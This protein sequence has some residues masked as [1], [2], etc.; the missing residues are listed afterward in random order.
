MNIHVVQQDETINSIAENYQVS[1]SR[2]IRENELDDPDYLVP[3]QTIV[4]TYPNRVYTVKEGDSL[5]IIA[6]KTGVTVLQLLRNNAFLAEREYIYPGESLVVSYEYKGVL[7]TFGYTLPFVNSTILRKSLPYLTYLFIYNHRLAISGDVVTFY[8]DSDIIKTSREYGTAP[9]ML[10]TTLTEQGAENVQAA[11]EILLNENLQDQLIDNILR[12]LDSKGYYGLCM[13]FLYLTE[14]SQSLYDNFTK[15][16]S[17]RLSS[18]GYLVFVTVDPN[19]S[20][21]SNNLQFPRVDYSVIGS[22]VNGISILSYVWGTN[23]KPPSPVS[24]IS[25]LSEYLNYVS[26]MVPSERITAGLQILSFNTI[27]CFSIIVRFALSLIPIGSRTY[28]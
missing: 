5:E 18:E 16:V 1:V 9:I 26:T 15:K 7:T 19:I 6:D 4:I 17:R 3:G 20:V 21:I 12:I 14:T 23:E 22:E 10:V 28:Q 13:T 27:F 25:N 2:L 8:D 24:S 11:Y